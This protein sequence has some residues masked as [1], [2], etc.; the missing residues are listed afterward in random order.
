MIIRTAT[1]NL[2][3]NNPSEFLSRTIAIVEAQG[4]YVADSKQWS[5]DGRLRASAT[6][7]IPAEKLT[8]ALQEIKKD[9]IR[10]NNDSVSGQDVSEEYADLGAQLTNLRAA[11]VELRQLL[12]TVRE[13]SQKASEILEVYDEISKVRGEIERLQGR[14]DFI[15]QMTAMST[16]NVELMPDVF[17][18]VALGWKPLAIATN[19]A[20]SL[21]ATLQWLIGLTI[22]IFIL[23][24]PLVLL[25][26]LL[27]I[28]VKKMVKPVMQ[29]WGRQS[30]RPQP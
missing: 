23:I 26:G 24:L 20:R 21:I 14:V 25:F 3:V 2:V 17:A 5:Q 1:L 4:G 30:A 6:L 9:A 12:T 27:A 15:K 7:R 11:E 19:A 8:A 10:V 28:G 29:W 18:V 16:I 22:W 13:R